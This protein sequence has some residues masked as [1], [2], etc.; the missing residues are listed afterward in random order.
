[1][2][3]ACLQ[4]IGTQA[5]RREFGDLGYED[6]R[7][8]AANRVRQEMHKGGD[9]M[10]DVLVLESEDDEFVEYLQAAW[11]ELK[12]EGESHLKVRLGFQGSGRSAPFPNQS[13]Q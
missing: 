6:A 5:A 9:R 3:S 8:K 10:R 12:A 1:M 4:E 11:G 2:W 7:H 13:T